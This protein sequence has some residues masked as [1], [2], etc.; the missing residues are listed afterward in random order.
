MHAILNLK[1]SRL[2]RKIIIGLF[3]FTNLIL[4]F[5]S[6]SNPCLMKYVNA[7]A[8]M[9][10]A[11]DEKFIINLGILIIEF[12]SIY[13]LFMD[14]SLYKLIC[15]I[16]LHIMCAVDIGFCIFYIVKQIEFVIAIIVIILDLIFICLM[17]YDI[18]MSYKETEQE[19]V[20]M[21][22]YLK[23]NDFDTTQ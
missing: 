2:I 22:E 21:K 3:L 12:V 4:S 15:N 18:I 1:T 20:F 8:F 19:K 5:F 11:F 13:S 23:N 9:G 17:L 14:K 7:Y 10:C 6:I 16:I